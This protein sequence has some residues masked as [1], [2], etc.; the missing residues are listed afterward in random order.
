MAQWLLHVLSDRNEEN[1]A[2]WQAFDVAAAATASTA[3]TL[4]ATGSGGG[5]GGGSAE[6]TMVVGDVAA[7]CSDAGA[8]FL[9]AA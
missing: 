1:A 4:V 9:A 6:I 3:T 5:G 8:T 7:T 2:A